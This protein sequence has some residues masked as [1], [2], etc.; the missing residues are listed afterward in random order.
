M[1]HGSPEWESA[2]TYGRREEKDVRNKHRNLDACF[3]NLC[4]QFIDCEDTASTFVHGLCVSICPS[5]TTDTDKPHAMFS[6]PAVIRRTTFDKFP[7]HHYQNIEATKQTTI[8]HRMIGWTSLLGFRASVHF[9]CY[10]LD[11]LSVPTCIPDHCRC[12]F[13]MRYFTQCLSPN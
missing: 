7:V 4:N 9:N 6:D 1:Q 11:S 3:V 10:H 8:V 2:N 5:Q 12:T 13:E